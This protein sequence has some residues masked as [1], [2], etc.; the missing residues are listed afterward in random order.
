MDNMYTLTGDITLLS[1]EIWQTLK[2]KHESAVLADTTDFVSGSSHC[3]IN[4]YQIYDLNHRGYITINVY[5]FRPEIASDDFQV[6]ASVF[7]PLWHESTGKAKRLHQEI[8]SI[9]LN[10]G[11]VTER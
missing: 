9:L 10:H 6:K 11:P 3:K 2:K 8:E 4:T 7:S 1:N 5:F